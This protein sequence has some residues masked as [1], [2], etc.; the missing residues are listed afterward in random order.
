MNFAMDMLKHKIALA[1][2][3]CLNKF[4][5]ELL[6]LVAYST[7]IDTYFAANRILKPDP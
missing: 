4:R 5:L 1:F 7:S 3:T 2:F 6:S